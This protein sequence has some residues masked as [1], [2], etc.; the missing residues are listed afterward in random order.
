[1]PR[2]RP[3][4]PKAKFLK[5]EEPRSAPPSYKTTASAQSEG[6]KDELTI[7]VFASMKTNSTITVKVNGMEH[8]TLVGSGA[9]VSL[10]DES[11]VRLHGLEVRPTKKAARGVTG[12]ALNILGKTQLDVE[13]DK[14]FVRTLVMLVV[15]N[16][17]FDMLLGVDSLSRM[18]RVTTMLLSF[19]YNNV[20][21]L[22]D[23]VLELGTI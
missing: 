6:E 21:R 1:M 3:P 7:D 2:Q 5:K 17:H 14:K 9:E 20:Y 12:D 23:H 10:I 15:R 22:Y 11:L 4:T 8:R 16:C 18:G 13:F 19:V